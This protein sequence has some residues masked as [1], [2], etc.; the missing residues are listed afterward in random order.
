MTVAS[1]DS[2]E[3]WKYENR[4]TS[5]V[6]DNLYLPYSIWL[7]RFFTANYLTFVSLS[8]LSS[9]S[10]SRPRLSE[11]F[12]IYVSDIL[13]RAGNTTTFLTAV[14]LRTLI[15]LSFGYWWSLS[16]RCWSIFLREM[17]RESNNTL[18]LRTAL[19]IHTYSY[20]KRKWMS[21]RKK[22]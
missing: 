14:F 5:F 7:I 19:Q 17:L 13:F 3:L 20:P 6:L 8:S 4:I 21:F 10:D 22:T 16:R 2:S 15:C 9:I 11:Y 12:H 18:S 1:S